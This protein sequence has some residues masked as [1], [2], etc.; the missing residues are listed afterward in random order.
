M[1]EEK[2][3]RGISWVGPGLGLAAALLFGISTPLAKLLL[4]QTGQ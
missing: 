4:Q 1:S 3:R 2:R